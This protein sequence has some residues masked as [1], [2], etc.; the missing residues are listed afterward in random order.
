MSEQEQVDAAEDSPVM[1]HDPDADYRRQMKH[2]FWW[3][4]VG[5]A[6]VVFCYHLFS[7]ATFQNYITPGG[8]NYS[9]DYPAFALGG[10]ISAVLISGILPMLWFAIFLK[11]DY[12]R[13][14]GPL[15]LWCVL[16]AYSCWAD[17][18][19]N[20]FHFC[21]ESNPMMVCLSR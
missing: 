4:V 20:S 6:T 1:Q 19:V 9:T 12:R 14:A 16:G 13:Q 15:I 11:F 7:A 5:I 21:L 17:Y 2:R 18:S 3:R 8:P 10:T